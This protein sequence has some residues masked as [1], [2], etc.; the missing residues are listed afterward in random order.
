MSSVVHC[1]SLAAAAMGAV[2]KRHVLWRVGMTLA[3]TL[4][5]TNLA[6]ALPLDPFD[7]ELEAVMLG[8]EADT[9]ILPRLQISHTPVDFSSSLNPSGGA[10]SYQTLPGATYA[11][12]PLSLAAT[13]SFNPMSDVGSWTSMAT[14]GTTTW[15]G[16]GSFAPDV[17]HPGGEDVDFDATFDPVIWDYAAIKFFSRQ[18]RLIRS[19]GANVY[20]IFFI[21]VAVSADFDRIVL[22]KNPAEDRLWATT[23]QASTAP[24]FVGFGLDAGGTVDLSGSGT[25]TVSVVPEP[26]SSVVLL[27]GLIATLG[28]GWLSRRRA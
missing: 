5:G 27:G 25:F 14:L 21:P 6:A 16:S 22:P 11:F 1:A 24:G 4:A 8:Q 19:F 7:A 23:Q 9:E 3:M 18:G 28:L 15:T 2:A 12:L 17:S 26:A 13:G 20:T 10:F